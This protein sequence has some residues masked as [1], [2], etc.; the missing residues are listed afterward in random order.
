MNSAKPNTRKATRVSS[1]R[2]ITTRLMIG[3]AIIYSA[4]VLLLGG[5][6][7]AEVYRWVDREGRVQYS[8]HP[9]P[10]VDA[11]KV[12][13]K[14][15]VGTQAPAAAKGYQEQDQEFR[16]RR[17]EEQEKA[18][19]DAAAEQQAKTRL[20]NCSDAQAQLASL[21]NG[22]RFTRTNEKGER[23]YLDDKAISAATADATKSVAD[24]CK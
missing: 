19:K 16:K 18:K 23:E 20:K 1:G 24:W 5:L 9:P 13:A 10:G 15:A 12:G 22:G 4:I 2:S 3:P 21:Q 8:D 14:P 7:H 6:A 11:K 17:V